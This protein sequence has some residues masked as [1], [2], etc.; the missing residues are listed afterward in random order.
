MGD[1]GFFGDDRVHAPYRRDEIRN[2]PFPMGPLYLQYNRM[3]RR[4]RVV[5]EW[6][7]G[8]IRAMWPILAGKWSG[9]ITTIESGR[10]DLAW[11]AACLMFNV[12]CKTRGTWPIGDP[13]FEPED[14][15]VHDDDHIP[16]LPFD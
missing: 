3:F 5:V 16:E 11:K 8:R 7:I 14:I 15:P 13:E 10:L 1:G 9:K 12:L 4:E 6:V 2:A